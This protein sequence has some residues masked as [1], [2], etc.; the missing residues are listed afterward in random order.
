MNDFDKDL[1]DLWQ[2]QPVSK[3]DV[4]QVKKRWRT[5][6]FRHRLYLTLDFLCLVPLIYLL[7]W[8]PIRTNS[9][10]WY[11]LIAI[12][13]A[14]VVYTIYLTWLRRLSLFSGKSTRDHLHLLR[15]Q[16]ANNVRI[17]QVSKHSAW[18]VQL[19]LTA[20]YLTLYINGGLPAAKHIPV[21]IAIGG[22][23]IA[24]LLF[25]LWAA[26]RQRRFARELEQLQIQIDTSEL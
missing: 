7:F 9:P 23:G 6:Q 17:A 5:F 15:K 3:I 10:E 24:N 20:F 8:S 13:F 18:V 22:A 19:A 21:V 12:G 1:N 2:S 14:A 16:L 26:R 11:F 4:N 25:Y